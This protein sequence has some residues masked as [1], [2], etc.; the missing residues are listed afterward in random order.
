[1]QYV[2]QIA[3]MLPD[4]TWH[5]FKAGRNVQV[6]RNGV[7]LREAVDYTLDYAN[8]LIFPRVQPWNAWDEHDYITVAFLY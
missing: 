6:W 7:L 4:G 2:N 5:Y 3:V 8:A 1:M